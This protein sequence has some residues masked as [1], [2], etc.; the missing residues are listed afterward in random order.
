MKVIERMWCVLAMVLVLGFGAGCNNEPEDEDDPDV[1]SYNVE[2]LVPGLFGN[3]SPTMTMNE[4]CYIN[5]GSQPKTYDELV[6][7]DFILY[8]DINLKKP[9]TGI[10]ILDENTMV[11][12]NFP[13]D[14]YEQGKNAG[15]IIGVISLAD[16]PLPSTTKVYIRSYS[17]AGYPDNWWNLYRKIDMSNVTDTSATVTWSLPVYESFGFGPTGN[18]ELIILPGDSLTNYTVSIPTKKIIDDMN[19]GDLGTVSIKGVTLSGTITVTYNGDLVPYVEIYAN[20][21]AKGNI[22]ITCLSSPEPNSPWSVTFGRDNNTTFAI[23]FLVKLY[24]GKS[25]TFLLDKYVTANKTVRIINNQNVA[26]I[27]LELHE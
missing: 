25:G 14:Y 3:M 4:W 9:F 17:F 5:S 6:Q 8:K 23:E 18:F 24:S 1:Y 2:E 26:D 7:E 11:Y 13:L 19:V 10:D 12:C 21:P 15:E 16:I 27:V 20:F 22:G